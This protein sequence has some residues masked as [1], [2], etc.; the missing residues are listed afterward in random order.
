M[1]Q[2][3]IT[4]NIE[5]SD[6]DKFIQ[7]TYG[8]P[9]CFQQQNDCRDRGSF[10]FSVPVEDIDDDEMFDDIPYEINGPD[11][12]VKFQTWL[13]RDPKNLPDDLLFWYRNFYPDLNTLVDDLHKKGLLEEGDYSI[14]VDW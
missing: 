8:K 2:Y 9:Y 6:W 13:S 4:K 3:N 11:M 12:G 1:L 7:E 10:D 5:C 14:I